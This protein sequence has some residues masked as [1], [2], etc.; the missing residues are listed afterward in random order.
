MTTAVVEQV[1][2]DRQEV[3]QAAEDIL[4]ELAKSGIPPTWREIEILKAAGVNDK[5]DLD[6]EVGRVT[7]VKQ[8]LQAAGT[9]SQW[10]AAEKELIESTR[11]ENSRRPGLEQKLAKIQAELDALGTRTR[12]AQ[13]TIGAFNGAREHLQDPLLM[14]AFIR[15]SH[16]AD[17]HAVQLR[18]HKRI[19][20]LETELS[21]ID[22]LSK[23]ELGTIKGND[24]ALLHA[25]TAAPDVIARDIQGRKRVDANAW[26]GYVKRRRSRRVPIEMELTEL[27]ALRDADIAKL[28]GQLDYYINKLK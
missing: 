19:G 11:E 12:A 18:H 25:E 13:Q 22:G 2:R 20:E 23:I 10:T 16:A 7:R 28:R 3:L 1:V 14:P 26:A 5:N 6:R 15:E 4:W 9:Q 8:L 27:R 21:V 17:V 24:Q